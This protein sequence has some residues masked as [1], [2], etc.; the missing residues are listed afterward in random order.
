MGDIVTLKVTEQGNGFP[1]IGDCLLADDHTYVVVEYLGAIHTGRPG[2]GNY[3]YVLAE[4]AA[5]ECNEPFHAK[6]EVDQ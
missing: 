6:A 1:D 5:D 2:S 4:P 3:C